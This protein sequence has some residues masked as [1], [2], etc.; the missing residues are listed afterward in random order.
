MSDAGAPTWGRKVTVGVVDGHPCRL[1]ADRAHSVAEFLLT[2]RR[3]GDRELLVQGSRRLTSAEH[4]AAVARVAAGLR[5]RGIGP[6]DRVALVGFNSIEW[7]V[8][9]WAVQAT[10]GTAVLGNAWWSDDELSVALD[11]A[12]P[13][14]VIT[15]RNQRRPA[16]SMSGLRAVV[17]RVEDRM[18]LV[19]APPDED[20]L[21]IIMFSSGTTGAPKGVLMSHRAVVANIHNLLVLTGRLPDEL[22]D[23]HPGTVSMLS[24]PLF[25]LAGVQVGCNTLLSGGRLVFLE[26]KFDPAEVLR[27][28]ET[29]RVRV[30]G[31][32]PTMVTR[33]LDH[34]DFAVR[35]VSSVSSVPM[36]GSAVSPELRERVAAAF[37]GVKSRVGSLYGLTE[38][39]GVL[40]AGSGKDVAERP[41]CVGRALPVVELRILN[42]DA[43]GIG[44][45]QARTPTSTGGYLG[46]KGAIADPDGWIGSGDLGRIDE[47]GWLY[48]TGR[49]KD[50]I[51]RGGENVGAVHVEERLLTH[52]DV[53]EAAVV[54]LP[55]ADLGEEVAAAVVLRPDAGAR[56]ADLEAHARHGLAR[57]EVPT[58]WWVRASSLPLNASGKVLRREVRRE[59]LELGGTTQDERATHP[60]A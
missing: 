57:Y 3:W 21:S 31:S 28:I 36:G 16:L 42:P 9:F 48:V 29:E 5:D 52:P 6:G 60:T 58:A 41:G 55:H 4:E 15:D 27:L 25:H 19:L 51:I 56:I 26:G 37:P 30:W 43:D 23:D 12:D 10:G 34:P 24:V 33:V 59:W 50:V 49:S 38:A 47:D 14:L 20:A 13:T 8:A 2:A 53:L 40:A 44:E 45:I 7:L 1:Y 46:E 11:Q 32:I 35:D 39:G 54:A 22:S 17:D 18:P